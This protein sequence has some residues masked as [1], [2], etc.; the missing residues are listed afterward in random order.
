[1]APPVNNQLQDTLP[2]RL[3]EFQGYQIW[4]GKNNKSNDQMLKL[5]QKND[6][7]LHA[8][9]VAGSHVIIKKKGSIYPDSVIQHA[10]QLAA[11]NSKAKTQ[12]V[13]PVIAVLRKFVSKPKN[14]ALG[15]V[16]VQKEE[17]VD[18]FIA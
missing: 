4:V 13:V 15:E 10:A 1:L 8:K 7:W 2:Y 18:A 12:S 14:A 17:I 11:R 16:S 9:D 6:M 5:A 3:V